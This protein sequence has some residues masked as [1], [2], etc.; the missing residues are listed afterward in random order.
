[1]KEYLFNVAAIQPVVSQTL[2]PGKRFLIWLQG[3]DKRCPGCLSPDFQ[4][5]EAAY[6]IPVGNLLALVEEQKEIEGVTVS[7]GEPFL[8]SRTLAVFLKLIKERNLT[9][10]VFSGYSLKELRSWGNPETYK[11]LDLIDVLIAD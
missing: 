4:P 3:C 11:D 2:G 5:K 7:G 1:M 8:Q 10:I 9:V 6:L